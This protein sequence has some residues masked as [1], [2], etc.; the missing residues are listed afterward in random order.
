M[1]QFSIS[2]Y[3]FSKRMRGNFLTILS[4]FNRHYQYEQKLAQLL[5]KVDFKDI[6]TGL[7]SESGGSPY[8]NN[9]RVCT[10]YNG[11]KAS[12]YTGNWNQ[13]TKLKQFWMGHWKYISNFRFFGSFFFLRSKHA[14]RLLRAVISSFFTKIIW[15]RTSVF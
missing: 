2:L 7:K 14:F 12:Y 1:G 3:S 10:L 13:H 6:H 5:W 11:M 9:E 15:I 8:N 4:F